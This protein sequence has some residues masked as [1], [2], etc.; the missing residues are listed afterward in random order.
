MQKRVVAEIDKVSESIREVEAELLT[1]K[2]FDYRLML[3]SEATALF[4]ETYDRICKEYLMKIRDVDAASGIHLSPDG[5]R[6]VFD[7]KGWVSFWKA[8]QASDRIGCK[9]DYFIRF[10]ME[11][12]LRNGWR[13][14]PR[15]NQLY[16]EELVL[17]ARDSWTKWQQVSLQLTDSE[18]FKAGNY[19]GRP[20]QD[21]YHLYLIGQINRRSHKH[22]ALC[23]VLFTEEMLPASVAEKHFTRDEIDMAMS[24]V[25]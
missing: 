13:Y 11:R 12:V 2:W 5:N 6:D 10:A 9:Y 16:G 25:Q 23:R 22:M 15:P 7:L 3:P 1:V 19:A 18:D 20:E 17:D 24:L 8:R 21:E 4:V 14:I